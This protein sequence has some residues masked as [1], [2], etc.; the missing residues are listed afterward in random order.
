MKYWTL[1]ATA[2]ALAAGCAKEPGAP[3]NDAAAAAAP[4]AAPGPVKQEIARTETTMT[5][6]PLKVPPAPV[7]LVVTRVDVPAGTLI[8]C[9]KHPWSRYVYLEAGAVRVTN[10][11]ANRTSDFAAGQEL[12][13]AID[14]WHDARVTSPGPARLVVVDQV[15]P[16][17]G[18]QVSAPSPSPC[19]RRP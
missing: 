10:Y 5:G 1:A 11:D 17:T 16:G 13:E 14:Q 19:V 7:Q 8:P 4:A 2:I 6:Q 12:V 3:G 18:N 9:H 15:P